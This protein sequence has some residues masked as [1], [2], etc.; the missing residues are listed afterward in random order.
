VTP[1]PPSATTRT[2]V[3]S[4]HGRDWFFGDVLHDVNGPTTVKRWKVVCQWTGNEHTEGC[5]NGYH[6]KYSELDC[7]M[8]MF[9]KSQ[10]LWMVERLNA[11]LQVAES[12]PTSMGELLKWFGV[13]LLITRFEFGE[14]ASLWSK[15]TNCKYVPAP[16][17]GR[18]G[19]SRLRFELLFRHMEWSHQPPVRPD[20]MSNEQHR[21]CL[22]Q[23]FV[24]RVNEHR[25]THVQPG[26]VICVD[27][28]MTRWYGLGGSWINCGLPMYVAIDRKP[29]NGCEIQDS[30]CARS[31]L[32]LK[33]KVVKS[34]SETE[35]AE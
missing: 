26:D 17:F 29:E 13:M 12:P 15:T 20:D 19:M 35:A 30:C 11:N 7:F 32:M 14:R 16:D 10:L 24:R 5:D 8:A 33:L 18:T 4:A 21:W 22:I 23:D 25:A 6:H 3:A 34:Q 1:T 2:P 9:P 27:E 31:N 28:S